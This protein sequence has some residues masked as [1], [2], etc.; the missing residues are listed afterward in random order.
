MYLIKVYPQRLPEPEQNPQER[1]IIETDFYSDAQ[2][3]PNLPLVPLRKSMKGHCRTG[4]QAC[5]AANLKSIND[6][7]SIKK[8]TDNHTTNG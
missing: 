7:E 4:Q 6:F 3:F 5:V 8:R 1:Q 2:Q